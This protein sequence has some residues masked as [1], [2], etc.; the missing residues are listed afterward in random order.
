MGRWRKVPCVRRSRSLNRVQ[1]V[2]GAVLMSCTTIPFGY[3][4]GEQHWY[5]QVQRGE[6]SILTLP[7]LCRL[8]VPIRKDAV[9]RDLALQDDFGFIPDISYW[10]EESL[11]GFQRN[12]YEGTKDDQCLLISNETDPLYVD[13]TI[14]SLM[15]TH[16]ELMNDP[17]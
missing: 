16:V 15:P 7:N 17:V 13:G 9:T 14:V 6:R 2:R 1:V 3:H 12:I 11:Q 8:L 4:R 5:D 10:P